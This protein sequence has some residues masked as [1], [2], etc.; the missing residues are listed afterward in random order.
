MA[1]VR[2]LVGALHGA[3]CSAVLHPAGT[4]Y[5]LG[6][7]DGSVLF[8]TDTDLQHLASHLGWPGACS[9]CHGGGPDASAEAWAWLKARDGATFEDPGYCH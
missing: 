7:G 4:P 5:R 2:L 6:D 1:P 3:P 9:C 8:Q